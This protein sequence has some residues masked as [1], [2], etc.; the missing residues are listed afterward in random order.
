[1]MTMAVLARYGNVQPD[2]YQQMDFFE[3]AELAKR[4]VELHSE[5]IEADMKFR[6]ELTKAIVKS[7]GASL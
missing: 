2:V 6:A 7:N 5:E 1:M 3:A 4:V